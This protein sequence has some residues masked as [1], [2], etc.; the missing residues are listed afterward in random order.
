MI[1]IYLFIFIFLNIIKNILMN[2]NLFS[3]LKNIFINSNHKTGV[4]SQLQNNHIDYFESANVSQ[5]NR[6][7]DLS[8]EEI[9]TE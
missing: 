4:K 5:E 7:K 6:P 2:N 9:S 1:I 8:G 3:I